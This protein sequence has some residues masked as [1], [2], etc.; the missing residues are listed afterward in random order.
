MLTFNSGDAGTVARFADIYSKIE[1]GLLNVQLVKAA[2]GP[3]IGTVDIKDFGVVNDENL[4]TLVSSKSQGGESLNQAVHRDLDVSK[5]EFQ[6]A[7]ARV[8][9]G[10]GYLRLSDGIAR[11][12][13]VGFAFQ[14]TLFD[15]QD[16]MN[17][18]GTFMP[19]YGLNRIFGEIPLLGIILGNGRDRG[20]IGITF[21]LTGSFSDPKLEINPISIIAPGIFRSIFQFRSED[22]NSG[23][24]SKRRSDNKNDR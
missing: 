24:S 20:L 17:I 22:P 5:A 21:R 10:K 19:A 14:G 1:G 6:H 12:P 11:G 16:N 15:R 9:M 2:S 18:T 8:D 3:Y 13:V 23:K 7:F 4:Q